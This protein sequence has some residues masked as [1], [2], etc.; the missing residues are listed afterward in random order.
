MTFL[1]GAKK[2]FEYI[3]DSYVNNKESELSKFFQDRFLT[4]IKKRLKKERKVTKVRD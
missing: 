1:D 4:N 3:I 2:A